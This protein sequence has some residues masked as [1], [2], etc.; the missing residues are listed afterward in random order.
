MD[1]LMAFA[2]DNQR[3]SSSCCHL[4][5]PDRLFSSPWLFQICQ[6]ADMMNLYFLFRSA[7]FTGIGKHTLKQF[8]PVG[9]DEL[10]KA[11]NKDRIA[12]PFEDNSP[13]LR[14]KRFLAFAA[15]DDNLQAFSWSMSRLDG[16]F[17]L[18]AIL[19]TVDLCLPAS[20]LS[21]EVCATQCSL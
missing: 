8:A 14:H 7:E 2:A 15:L 13:K 19:V 1:L 5:N 10:R 4:F 18:F 11:I 3:F 20:V 9:H 17:V 12:L 16:G 21:S 6:F